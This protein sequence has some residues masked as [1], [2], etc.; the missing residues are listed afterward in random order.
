MRLQISSTGTQGDRVAETYDAVLIGAGVN[1]LAAA[2]H[3]ASRGQRVAVFEQADTAGGAVKT[4]AYTLP[5]FRHDW[6]AMN[7]SLF[8]GS[9]FF[10]EHGAEL[11]R[12]GCAF[13]PTGG[14]SP[15]A[16]PDGTWCGVSTDL[17][18]TTARIAALSARTPRPGPRWCRASG[19]RRRIC[20][21][22][23]PAR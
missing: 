5:G 3:L 16:L 8:A 13:V 21:A 19:P 22:C 18:E 9:G 20:S 7:L 17:A 10:K 2:L 1:T 4:G 12:H 15:P 14:P 6:A 23:S 11:T